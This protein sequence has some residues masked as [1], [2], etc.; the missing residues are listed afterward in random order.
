[1]N[2]INP[3]IIKN[4]SSVAQ[5]KRAGLITQRSVDRNYSLLYTSFFFF[6]VLFDEI[7]QDVIRI[8][9]DRVLSI[10]ILHDVTLEKIIF[11]MR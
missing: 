5:W 1:M 10:S 9:A 3:T 6:R 7:S 4:A 8:K 2:K 11:K